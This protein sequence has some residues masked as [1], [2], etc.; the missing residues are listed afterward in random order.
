MTGVKEF[1]ATRTILSLSAMRK[2]IQEKGLYMTRILSLQ[3][4][5]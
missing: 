3:G 1:S 4:T 2:E 5:V